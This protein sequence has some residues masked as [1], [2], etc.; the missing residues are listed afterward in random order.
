MVCV[1]V[2]VCVCGGGGG[3]GGSQQFIEARNRMNHVE[4]ARRPWTTRPLHTHKL[5][6]AYEGSPKSSV[7]SFVIPNR[8]RKMEKKKVRMFLSYSSG[9]S[10]EF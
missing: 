8:L 5:T 1:C 10:N 2:C 9:L 3:G 7:L 4:S 6:H